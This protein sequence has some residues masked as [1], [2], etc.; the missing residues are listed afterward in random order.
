VIINLVTLISRPEPAHQAAHG[1]LADRALEMIPWLASG[2]AIV[3]VSVVVSAW[4]QRCRDLKSGSRAVPTVAIG[5]DGEA[6]DD[7]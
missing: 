6:G 1:V 2:F 3:M 4:V 7:G 5:R